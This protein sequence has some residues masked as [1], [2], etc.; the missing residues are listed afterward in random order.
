MKLIDSPGTVLS[1]VNDGLVR[2]I[3]WQTTLFIFAGLAL[4]VFFSGGQS[5][6]APSWLLKIEENNSK[7]LTRN[8]EN[9]STWTTMAADWEIR[10][11]FQDEE[12]E[13]NWAG[14]QKMRQLRSEGSLWWDEPAEQYF[15]SKLETSQFPTNCSEAHWI[16]HY[17]YVAG[18]LSSLH[19]FL[20]P[21]FLAMVRGHPVVPISEPKHHPAFDGCGPNLAD[22]NMLC[23]FNITKCNPVEDPARLWQILDGPKHDKQRTSWEEVLME[24][25]DFFAPRGF[26]VVQTWKRPVW[27]TQVCVGSSSFSTF[28]EA[29]TYHKL[30]LWNS[31]RRHGKV[32]VVTGSASNT[33]RG[34]RTAR[35]C[36][37]QEQQDSQ[38][39]KLRRVDMVMVSLMS[40]WMLNQMPNYVKLVAD[41]IM[42]RYVDEF[43]RPLWKPP[44]LAIH[45]RQTDK[46]VEDPYFIEH[47][48]YRPIEDYEVHMKQMEED[49]GFQWPSIFLISDSGTARE[50]FVKLLNGNDSAVAPAPA[51]QLQQDG[52]RYFMYDWIEDDHLQEKF[53]DHTK[54][55]KALKYDMQ[56][57]FLATL[58]ILEKIADH[59]IVT[60]SSN[61]GRF[62][63]EIMAAKH[64]LAFADRQGPLVTSLD[65]P[66]YWA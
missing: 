8:V 52:K 9:W 49:Y 7:Q 61:V 45:I 40:S 30:S 19:M 15:K 33:R 66:W 48:V 1:V 4:I 24:E 41:E 64:R 50:S 47:G 56:V 38:D 51:P 2:Q 32:G 12:D 20:L 14:R 22:R 10:H 29:Y 11:G 16:A 43:G 34:S 65:H 6:S 26:T 25:D 54:V 13:K 5:P 35:K 17:D 58:Y 36:S 46:S 53:K 57:H 28:V 62:I 42:S 55:P 23:Y 59:A 3:K 63:G 18:L 21:L 31:M 44:V 37:V 39:L 27:E 60:Y